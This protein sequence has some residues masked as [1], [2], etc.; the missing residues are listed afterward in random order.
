MDHENTKKLEI[1]K[2][3][4]IKELEKDMELQLKTNMIEREKLMKSNLYSSLDNFKDKIKNQISKEY[5]AKYSDLEDTMRK[6]REEL[7]T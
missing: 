7:N 1:E 6:E 2:R 5:K 3:K 4:L